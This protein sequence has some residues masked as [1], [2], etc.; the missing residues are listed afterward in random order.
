M[1][2]P[3]NTMREKTLLAFSERGKIRN[4]PVDEGSAETVEAA[5]AEFTRESTESLAIS[6]NDPI[7]CTA[8]KST[9]LTQNHPGGKWP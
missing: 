5:I 6:R 7:A 9:A 3:V 1:S 2:V 8:F 4:V